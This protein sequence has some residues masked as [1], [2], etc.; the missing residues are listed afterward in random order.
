[1]E[2]GYTQVHHLSLHLLGPFALYTKDNQA[3]PDL[4]RKTRALLA[5]LA[6]AKRPYTRH[7]LAGLFCQEA[8]AP[9]RAL[10]HLLS[11]LRAA[12][13]PNVLWEDGETIQLDKK[14]IWVDAHYFTQVLE[15]DLSQ[16]SQS[17]L[18]ETIALYHGEYLAGLHLPDS[19]EFE[20]WLL[21]YRAHLHRLYERSALA[22]LDLYLVNTQFETALPL[23]QQ[24][25]QHSPLL[26][27][28]HYCLISLYAQTNQ[29]TAALNQYQRC[30]RL[31]AKELAV[32]PMPALVT[33][34]ADILA[35]RL[36]PA[37]SFIPLP[38][39]LSSP[40]WTTAADFVGREK[41]LAQLQTAWVATQRGHT[42][43]VLITAEAGGG[44]TR[45]A[46]EFIATLANVVPLMGHCYESTRA[47]AYQPW[48]QLLEKLLVH[49]DENHWRTLPVPWLDELARLLPMLA[50]K[51]SSP[52]T[53][54]PEQ[55]FAAV[56][57]LL[58]LWERPCLLFLDDLQWA[59]A[60]SLQ[61]LHYV[62][63]RVTTPILMMAVY[64][65]EEAEDNPAL[66]TLLRDW[67][68]RDDV[69]R[70][71]LPPISPAAIEQLLVQ[72]WP[73][74][75][76]RYPVPHLRD[77]LYQATGGNPLFIG[78]I[79]R[80]LT[81]TAHLPD[82][83][84]VPPSLRDLIQRRLHQLPG[85]GRQVLESLAVLEQP[86]TLELAQQISARSEE[87]M[88]QALESGLRW[89]LL[90]TDTASH[91]VEFSHDL[92]RQ[93]VGQQLSHVRRQLLHRRTAV[94]LSKQGAK[95]A[96]LAYHWHQAGD[97]AQEAIYAVQAGEEAAAVYAHKEAIR[98]L[99]LALTLLPKPAEQLRALLVLGRIW[100]V[101][102]QWDKAETSYQQ[103]FELAVAT[104]NPQAMALCQA[105]FG[106]L[107]RLKG[108]YDEAI[109][110]LQQAETGFAALYDH[111][112]LSQTYGGLGAIY[113]AQF[114]YPRALAY[115]EKQLQNA[116]Q[117]RD[118]INMS[119]AL[120]SLGVIHTELGHYPQ[121]WACYQQQ[122]QIDVA[123]HYRRGVIQS[124]GNMG[125][126]YAAQ[127][128]FAQALV[129]YEYLLHQALEL[130]ERLMVS[131]GV[132][133]MVDVY[134]AQEHYPMA[135]RLCQQA[136]ALTRK[137][138]LPLYLCG[139]LHAY[140][141][142]CFAQEQPVLAQTLNDQALQLARE[143]GRQDILFT[144]QVLAAKLQV[145]LNEVS[146]T[147]AVTTLQTMLSH[148]SENN[149]QAAIKTAIWQLDA[150]QTA[151]QRE[152]ATLYHA[153]HQQSPN[154]EY[155]RQYTV[156]T[157][158]T[159]PDPSPAPEPPALV[160]ENRPDFTFLLQ[161]VDDL[162]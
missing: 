92:M 66:L 58:Q 18:A 60:A 141:K 30:R 26:E 69:I 37:S 154:V 21:G 94:A 81:S 25:V 61:L 143:V 134:L 106:R 10:R 34:H 124:V 148:W 68:R 23:A 29:R 74:L 42:S 67:S 113:W 62:S 89:R 126:L 16:L 91:Q 99:E 13:G 11:R 43:L 147:T 47:L 1:M 138:N 108:K 159:L 72:L 6:V 12:L 45:L 73:Q 78:E 3:T 93:A 31:L 101:T 137:L 5:Y 151:C 70:L 14:H 104:Q 122:L 20:L 63:E 160:L 39:L 152:A 80:E 4:R 144:G 120:G 75:P 102:S 71:V 2:T 50:A 95:A 97:T 84:P 33:L 153:L 158:E 76:A 146:V 105:A 59:D 90:Q 53:S 161:R 140:A 79:V 114:D 139:N 46:Q 88:L 32:E 19:P 107:L 49:L 36:Q 125:M 98:Y 15:A 127:G 38:A 135:E 44:K 35:G 111:Q 162:I 112:G 85:S 55:L 131:V 96:T 116:S 150:T 40:T 87:E 64:R 121:A 157:A 54:Q 48:T 17:T 41:E 82:D 145:V 117:H 136:I 7:E 133:N 129:C 103:A 51:Q 109:Q 100:Q 22:L 123:R 57:G 118:P 52:T 156:L 8:D 115:F 24:V 155:R 65:S 9:L 86:A 83:L 27:E 119:A 128:Q 149:E 28:A 130:G 110:W 56:V 142:V 77:R 132:G